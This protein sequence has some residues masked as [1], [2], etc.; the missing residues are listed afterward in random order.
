MMAQQKKAP[1]TES[2]DLSSLSATHMVGGENRLSCVPT[3]T[4]AL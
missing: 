4:C 3:L 2:D 1:A